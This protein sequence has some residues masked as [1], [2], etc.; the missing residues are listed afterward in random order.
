M[1]CADSV[2]N[3]GGG[4]PHKIRASLRMVLDPHENLCGKL[5]FA[6]RFSPHRV[7]TCG[8]GAWSSA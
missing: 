8:R 5:R 1:S 6:T 3:K 2:D 4:S 7:T